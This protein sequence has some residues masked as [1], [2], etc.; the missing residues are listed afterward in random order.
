MRAGSRSIQTGN[1][2]LKSKNGSKYSVGQ[3][4][5]NRVDWCAS[6]PNG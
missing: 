2:K 5:C 4:G 1:I 3:T 6:A